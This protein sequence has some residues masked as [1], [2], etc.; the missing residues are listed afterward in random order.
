MYSINEIFRNFGPEYIQLF[1]KSMPN[2]HH[3]VIDAIIKCRTPECGLVIYECAGCGEQ[4]ISFRSCGNRHCP[5]CQN[6]KTRLW[7]EKQMSQQLPGHYF[8]ITVTLPEQLRSFTRSNQRA[9]YAA[10]FKASSE[11]IKKLSPDPKYIGGDLP[12]FFGVLH[13]WGRQLPYHPHIHYIV[14]GGAILKEDGSW[15][16]SR[17]DFYL[18]V[19]AMSKIVR[20]KFYE[21]MKKEGLLS[22]INPEVWNIDWNIN[23]Q[24]IGDGEN[25]IKYLSAY[26][27]KV[28]ISD[29]RI[30][31]V[32]NREVYFQYKK[33]G[34]NRWRTM[35]LDVMEFIRRFLQ[36]VLPT[37]FMKIRYYGFMHP[38]CSITIDEIKTIMEKTYGLKA[39]AS[40]VSIKIVPAITCPKC[41]GEMK[42]Y[43]SVLPFQMAPGQ[44]A[45]ARA[46]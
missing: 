35:H 12:G 39:A 34:S 27:F 15:H 22:Q 31:K 19:K 9:V 32:E 28:G 17:I 42:Y 37:G 26:V 13:T 23:C 16:P 11:T 43:C 44:M 5:A 41:G 46:G 24:A 40:D 6:H 33:K 30:I 36:H 10:M 45:P 38:S 7:V 1:G 3:K 25:S 21:E 2:E 29:S 14:P 20:A 18:P 4:H 8:M